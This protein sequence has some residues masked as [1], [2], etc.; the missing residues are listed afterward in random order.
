MI[1]S[2]IA[3][4]VIRIVCV[5]P[6]AYVP[7]TSDAYATAL[8]SVLSFRLFF[9]ARATATTEP[10]EP[11]S[12]SVIVKFVTVAVAGRLAQLFGC[13]FSSCGSSGLANISHVAVEL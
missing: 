4:S 2:I 8:K 12:V 9:A 11:V 7:I 13:G 10:Y 1:F 3:R 5:C 6:T